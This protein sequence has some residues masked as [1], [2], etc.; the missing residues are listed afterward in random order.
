VI[1][2]APP[3]AAAVGT[4]AVVY[5]ESPMCVHPEVTWMYSATST[6]YCHI[7]ATANSVQLLATTAAAVA[8]AGAA[9]GIPCMLFLAMLW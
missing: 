4:A 6:S 1:L 5:K 7:A 9:P 8:A 3:S 2:D